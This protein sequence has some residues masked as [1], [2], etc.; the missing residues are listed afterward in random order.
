MHT[1]RSIEAR[2]Y[3]V[4]FL[5][6][7]ST[8][9]PMAVFILLAQARGMSLTQIGLLTA[10]YAATIVLLEVPTGGLADAWGRA[11]VAFLAEAITLVGW[12]VFLFSFSLPMFVAAFLLNGVGRALASGSLDAWFVDG[13]LAVDPNVD[14]HPRLS[15]A[16]A[17]TLLALG[18][19]TVTGG[20]IAGWFSFLP[21]D[22]TA[23]LTPLSSP[24]LIALPLRAVLMV[25]ILCLI[26]EPDGSRG[27]K[28]A[29]W[30]R[31]IAEVPALLR[32]AVRLTTGNRILI[33]L[34]AVA[35][36]SGL[37]LSALEVLWQ[38]R[39]GALLGDSGSRSL[40]L[41]VVIA[42][43][44][45]VG[46][47]GN[48]IAPRIARRLGGRP[49]AVCALFHGLRG[50]LLVGLALQSHAVPAAILF[51]LVYLG[52][53]AVVST[54]SLLLNEEIPAERRSS[55]LSIESLVSYAGG[56]LGSAGLGFVADRTSIPVA[57]GLAGGVLLVSWV[58][59]LKVDRARKEKRGEERV[60]PCQ[61]DAA[62]DV[63]RSVG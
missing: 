49:G 55:M 31:G 21:P 53:G 29:S 12:I 61:A 25:A 22:G 32:D 10:L 60:L 62:A 16:G 34:L 24:G 27:R 52:Q 48:L 44:F 45:L 56:F 42:G 63:G 43:S 11:R 36:A 13:L 33:R 28:G 19:G 20:A 6:W 9:L 17:V 35:G 1:I 58:L 5:F 40:L 47:V 7:F 41:G 30:T 14:L 51:W 39:F 26:R 54:H 57:W 23:V 8:A 18:L 37:V 46:M 3:T 59:Y 50:A 4:L 15:R 38:P 2:F